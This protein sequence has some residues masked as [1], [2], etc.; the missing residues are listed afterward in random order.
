MFAPLRQLRYESPRH[1]GERPASE[2]PV[3]LLTIA[4][5][6]HA[7]EH[8]S[9]LPLPAAIRRRLRDRLLEGWDRQLADAARLRGSQV[10]HNRKGLTP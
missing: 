1:R 8:P 6:V 10:E 2:R 5:V 3:A 4:G 9:P 7:A